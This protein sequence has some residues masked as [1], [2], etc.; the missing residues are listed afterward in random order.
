MKEC[1]NSPININSAE[2]IPKSWNNCEGIITFQTGD[3]YLGEF[4]NRAPN[5]QGTHFILD[6]KSKNYGDIFSGIF[7]DWMRQSG[8]YYYLAENDYKGDIFIGYYKNDNVDNGTL[9][10][11]GVV[12]KANVGDKYTGQFNDTIGREGYG[13]YTFKDG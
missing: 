3:K 5:G 7:E 6:K 1:A 2:D 9:Y 11:N 13:I 12:H 8:S 10:Y 4:Y